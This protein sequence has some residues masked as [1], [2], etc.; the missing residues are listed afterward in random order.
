MTVPSITLATIDVL[1]ELKEAKHLLREQELF[2]VLCEWA[3]GI[4]DNE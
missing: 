2:V 1:T 3:Q 4:E